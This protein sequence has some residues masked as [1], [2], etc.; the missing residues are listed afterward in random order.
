[1]TNEAD[2]WFGYSVAFMSF[3]SSSGIEVTSLR[4]IGEE[5]KKGAISLRQGTLFVRGS[6][7]S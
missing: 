1:M 6:T 7:L 5:N 4:L 3:D 2:V